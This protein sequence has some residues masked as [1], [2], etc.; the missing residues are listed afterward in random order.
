MS[1]SVFAA[2]VAALALLAWGTPLEAQDTRVQLKTR[3]IAED[4]ESGIEGVALY[5]ERRG[6]ARLMAALEGLVPD[7]VVSFTAT[8]PD[9]EAIDL[10]DATADEDGEASVRLRSRGGDAVPTIPD[11]TLVEA[12]A[13]DGT[14]I[15]SGVLMGR[16]RGG[17]NADRV[18]LRARLELVD[19]SDDGSGNAKWESRADRVRLSVEVEDL[20]ADR[21]LIVDV[22]RLVDGV[23]TNVFTVTI[24]TDAVGFVDLNLDSRLGD[25]VPE[26]LAGDTVSVTDA[27]TGEPV[28]VGVLMPQ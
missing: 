6:Q 8:T 16:T 18:R 19:G 27:A 7:E 23:G 21:T 15:A 20:G 25:A 1:R 12:I 5:Q 2:G 26:L 24:T 11:G 22:T 9:G 28:L 17:G 14:L 4:A 3:L 13:A 10:G